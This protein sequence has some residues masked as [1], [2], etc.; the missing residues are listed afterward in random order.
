MLNNGKIVYD[1]AGEERK[2][3]TVSDLVVKFRSAVGKELDD[4]EI[5]LV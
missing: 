2:K 3:L 5:L 1:T 4:D